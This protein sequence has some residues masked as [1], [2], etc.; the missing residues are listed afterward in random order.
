MGKAPGILP[1]LVGL[2]Q[3]AKVQNLRQVSP[4][5]GKRRGKPQES[6]SFYQELRTSETDKVE[7]ERR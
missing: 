5:M 6:F 2:T 1:G 7:E 3:N 4:K